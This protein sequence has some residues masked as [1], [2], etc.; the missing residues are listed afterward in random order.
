MFPT[1]RPSS[2][3]SRAALTAVVI[4]ALASA[5]SWP[6]DFVTEPIGSGWDRPTCIAFADPAN[7]LVAEKS[8]RV[9]NV[10]AGVKRSTPIIDLRSEV[11][12]NGDRGLLTLLPDTEWDEN[13]YIYLG[14]IVDPNA[15]DGEDE[16]ES[17][18]RIVRFTTFFDQNGDLLADPKSRKT[19]IGA[20]W[21]NGIP[22]LHYSHSI[23]DMRIAAD[24]SLFITTGDGAHYDLTDAGGWDPNGFGSGKFDVSE[25]IGAFRSQS[26]TSLAGKVLRIDPETGLGLA[27]NPFFTGIAAENQ[28][29]V[30]AW[31]LRNPFRFALRPNSGIPEQLFIGDVGWGT[32]EEIDSAQRLGENFGWPC[33]EGHRVES[34]YDSAD[35]I[36]ACDDPTVFTKP[37]WSFHHSFPG[38]AGFTMQ[39]VSGMQVYEGSEYP[40][41]YQGRLFFC[42]YASD[43]IRTVRF[44]NGK[45]TEVDLFG[46]DIGNP[47]DLIA[48]PV[49]GDLIY[50][51]IGDN[52]IRRIRYTNV[53]HPPAVV[54]TATPTFGPSPLTVTF[55]ASGSSDPEG[56]PLSYLWDFG[57]GTTGTNAVENHLYP[58]GI[59]YAA[60]LVVT[61]I[62]GETGDWSKLISVD[63][64]PP[65]IVQINSPPQPSFFTHGQLITFDVVA[66]D[67]EDG[68]AGLPLTIEW[69]IDLVHDHHNHP[70]WDKVLGTPVVWKARS[71]GEGTYFHVT[72]VVID[73][74]GLRSS[75]QF[76]LFDLDATPHPHLESVSDVA[77]RLGVAVEARAHLHYAGKGSAD[78]VFDWGDGLRQTF[79]PQHM[80]DRRPSHLYSA[81]GLYTLVVSASDGFDTESVSQV[82]QVRPLHPGVAIFVPGSATK[83]IDADD[84]WDIGNRLANDLRAGGWEAE[85]FTNTNQEAMARWMAA[86]KADAIR[87]Y[88]V[89]LDIGASSLYAGQDDGSLAEDWIEAGNGMVWTGFAPFAWYID[90]LGTATDIGAGDFAADDVLDAAYPGVCNGVGVMQLLPPAIDLPFLASYSA[91]RAA[92]FSHLGARWTEQVTYADDGKIGSGRSSDAMV[93][94]NAAGGEYAQF[95]IVNDDRSPRAEVL[96]D[97]LLS[98]LFADRPAG[99]GDF[100]LIF[101]R[102][103]EQGVSPL[104][105]KFQW[106]DD[107]SATSWLFE[108]ANDPDFAN[109]GE[110]RQI[111]GQPVL[112]L[113]RYL[114]PNRQYFWRVTARN[115]FG[116]RLSLPSRFTTGTPLKPAK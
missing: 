66:T 77:P 39:C 104:T 37:L 2:M 44:V 107:G 99:P 116:S 25:D 111:T 28:S 55:D 69:K 6:T 8:G 53:N 40:Q 4:P 98:H 106:E 42:E 38:G 22:S 47:V 61:D 71:E 97:F 14:Y 89:V 43:F 88:V 113:D 73:S 82:I 3:V 112:D 15:D 5:Q 7:L 54:A 45:P 60:S 16:Q 1:F 52:A 34:S 20:T 102:Q 29:K 49:N 114:R 36:K 21:T 70:S 101:P 64:T 65:T 59:D 11:L 63:N 94:R 13:G 24:G 31:G 108:L 87:D 10:R 35:P 30:W 18:G 19:L 79:K 12:D 85:I 32:F 67:A 115:D 17:F 33:F 50:V 80:Q 91:N 9:W 27:D 90:S 96:R 92:I 75:Q 109:V 62:G 72:C 41:K 78:L 83:W 86:Y 68:A 58:S 56:Q 81:P 26:L 51:A 84:Q 110:R 100:K 48:D 95:H 46:N 76:D 23:G 93:V 57:D 74:R 103:D 105:V